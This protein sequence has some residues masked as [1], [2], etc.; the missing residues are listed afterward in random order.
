M[1]TRLAAAGAVTHDRRPTIAVTLKAVDGPW[2]S[3]GA[4]T[5]VGVWPEQIAVASNEAGPDICSFVLRRASPDLPW[6]D[7]QAFNQCEIQVDGTPVWG[8]R[9]WEATRSGDAVAV[10]GRGWQYHLD[11][12]VVDMYWVHTRISD[13][14]DLRAHPDTN[15]VE[16]GAN[17]TVQAGAG[18]ITLGWPTHQWVQINLDGDR[19]GFYLD[20]GANR[21]AKRLVFDYEADG[22]NGNMK[23]YVIASDTQPYDVTGATLITGLGGASS[24]VVGFTLAT[25]RR[26]VGV[27]GQNDSVAAQN[28]NKE[29]F[30]KAIG[31][32]VFAA[33]AYESGGNS[34]LK[35]S[36]VIGDVLA[37]GALPLLSQDT[38]LITAGTVNI[39]SLAPDGYQT[40]RQLFEAANAY[41]GNL[42]GVNAQREVFSRERDTTATLEAGTTG[43]QFQDATT[44]T[45]GELYN[46]V[47]VQGTAPDGTPVSEVR[48]ASTGLL[49]R[50]GFN[51]TATLNVAAAV[52]ASAAQTLGDVWLGEYSQPKFKGS[53]SFQG[54]G[55]VRQT[56]GGGIHPSQLLLYGG[57]LV[58][59]PV[60]DAATGA[61]T[62]DCL[63][64]AVRYDH[65]SET[66]TV[67]LDN[68][69][70]NFATL[71]SRYGVDVGQALAKVTR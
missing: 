33:T 8:G 37:S 53:A 64:K 32:K 4:D 52:T 56:G 69:R 55:S 35:A 41:E 27:M 24:G 19:C 22:D 51:R 54:F 60:V 2:E 34:T 50:Q 29:A 28:L 9:V 26:Y 63:I 46:R 59:V 38:R 18:S 3:L 30:F 14:R 65:D 43:F 15:L 6:P 71:L 45:G 17:Q 61:W 47:V 44:N 13:W 39:P 36:T 62:R 16:V 57:R 66:A 11:D 5:A 48:T 10:Q 20:M 25:A 7:L 1:T 49:T 31:I 68:E 70:G 58:R 67:E 42:V 23:T 40:P 21:K 12:D